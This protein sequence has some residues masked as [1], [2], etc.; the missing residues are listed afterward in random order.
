MADLV[1][2]DRLPDPIPV[3]GSQI[4]QVVD[5]RNRVVSASVNGDRL[6]ALL[7]PARW[8]AAL[9]GDHPRSPGRGSA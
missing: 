6:T 9:D 5:S 2:R 8:R 4:V 3:T 7:T 1:D